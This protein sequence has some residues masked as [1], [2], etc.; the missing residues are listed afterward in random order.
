VPVPASNRA[1]RF[2]LPDLAD[3]R[4]DEAISTFLIGPAQRR[5]RPGPLVPTT[6]SSNPFGALENRVAWMEALRRE[7][8][9][10]VRYRRPAAVMVI[11]GNARNDTPEETAW[12]GRVAGP[13]AHAIRRGIRETD[14]V[15]R[16]GDARFQVLLPETTGRLAK[17]IADRV[18]ADCEIWLQAVGAPVVLRSSA[19]AA[20][21][22][23][24]LDAALDRALHVVDAVKPA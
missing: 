17:H 18:V 10:S 15:T 12:V 23:T 9:R 5:G 16:T 21:P 14:L 20:T 11:A 1:R 19:A 13:I 3:E 7:T 22:D 8:A 2:S 24:S 4:V 6:L